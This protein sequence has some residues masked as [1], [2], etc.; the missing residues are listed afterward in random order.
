M[1]R[2]PS[3]V[4]ARAGS[5]CK[6]PHCFCIKSHE[7]VR[8]IWNPNSPLVLVSAIMFAIGPGS[9]MQVPLSLLLRM[10]LRLLYNFTLQLTLKQGLS[11]CASKATVEKPIHA[12]KPPTLTNEKSAEADLKS[13]V[14]CLV[15][16]WIYHLTSSALLSLVQVLCLSER[17]C[18]RS[19]GE[20]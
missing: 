5:T 16:C 6:S 13:K 18:E 4:G 10:I 8:H 15:S 20:G 9:N 1:D 3:R 11:G 2:S 12:P 14:S 7:D 19:A 17:G